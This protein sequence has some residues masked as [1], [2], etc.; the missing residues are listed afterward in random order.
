[1]NIESEII[2]GYCPLCGGEDHDWKDVTIVKK[3]EHTE[4]E[5]T[6]KRDADTGEVHVVTRA[7]AWIR[8]ISGVVS[9]KVEEA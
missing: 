8:D 5:H 6:C 4:C 9:I 7:Q 1:M 2:K 3:G